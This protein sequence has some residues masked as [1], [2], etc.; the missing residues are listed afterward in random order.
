MKRDFEQEF[1]ALK[2]SEI[3]DLWNRIEAG[4][5]EKKNTRHMSQN[6]KETDRETSRKQ[7][8]W[9][10]W[11]TLIAACLCV[12]I[13]LPAFTLLVR[14]KSYSGGDTTM[15][16]AAENIA[17]DNSASESAVSEDAAAAEETVFDEPADEPDDYDGNAEGNL[18]DG[19]DAGIAAGSETE[20]GAENGA[21]G[22]G[23]MDAAASADT[24]P[25]AEEA[26][27]ARKEDAQ[28]KESGTADEAKERWKELPD[29]QILEDVIIEIQESGDGGTIYQAWVVQ[30][31]AGGLLESGTQIAVMCDVDTVYDFPAGPREEK[32]LTEDMAY[33]VD[34]RYD[35]KEEKFVVVT[36]ENTEGAFQ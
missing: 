2:Q 27:S 6:I 33:Q 14:N 15:E 7:F 22:T 30:A 8:A 21:A 5:S 13:I 32:T 29:G 24:A 36:A 35:S 10:R 3:P 16:S 23:S 17:M 20:A 4:L 18:S 19:T 25:E 11:G 1:R 9:R 26:A 28:V 12:V 34:L 31:D